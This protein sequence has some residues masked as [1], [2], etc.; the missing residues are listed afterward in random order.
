VT[1]IWVSVPGFDGMYEVSDQGR[2]RSLDRF[3]EN[4]LPNGTIRRQHIGGR[5]LKPG[6]AK[7]GGYHYVNLS[8]GNKKQRSHHVHRIVL[9]AFIGP[10]PSGLHTRHLNG[11][12]TDNRLANL[13]YGTPTENACDKRRHGTTGWTNECK[14][15]HPRTPE[16]VYVMRSG[17]RDCRACKR[18]RYAERKLHSA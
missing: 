1:E 17:F 18:E 4:P 3:I 16:N 2:V 6:I 14:R 12:P 13:A 10:Q 11:V 8:R 5:I 15:G 7:C 9:A